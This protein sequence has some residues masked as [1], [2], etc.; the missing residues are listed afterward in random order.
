[1]ISRRFFLAGVGSFFFSC[2]AVAQPTTVWRIGHLWPS[3]SQDRVPY[4]QGFREGLRT[5]GYIEGRNISIEYRSA[6]GHLGDL[7]ALA[8]ELAA[9]KVD[10][11][12]APSTSAALAA[13]E[14]TTSIPIIFV[15]VS[16]PIGSGLVKSLSRPGGN[17]TGLTDVGV[18][19]TGKRLDLLKQVVPHLKRVAVLGDTASTLWEPIWSEVQVAA[20]QLQIELV[21]VLITTPTQLDSAF[22]KLNRRVEAVYVAPQ[23]LFWVHRHKVIE[24]ASKARL[25]AIYEWRTFAE[26]GGLMSYGPSFVAL[27]RNAA[28]QIDKILRG[29]RPADLPVEQPTVYEF[30]INF[31]AAKVLG[32][33]ISQ[34]VLLSA[35]EI[36]R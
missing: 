1:V 34:S 6:E 20:R 16:D 29:A 7:P 36:L 26:A 12:L 4:L 31:K 33:T 22:D 21:P 11:I 14:A 15:G 30:V 24:L 2:Y 23:P 13:K 28:Y 17:V 3:T 19:L 32:L 5:L 35:D 9:L 18:D 8:R 27:N 25:P 10:V